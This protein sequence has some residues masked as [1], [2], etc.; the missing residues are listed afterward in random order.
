MAGEVQLGMFGRDDERIGHP[1]WVEKW[2]NR[3]AF[4]IGLMTG[5]GLTAQRICDRLN[6]GVTPNMITA[7]WSHWGHIAGANHHTYAAIPV[8]LSGIHRTLID[9]EAERRRMDIQEI[10]QSVLETVAKEDLW[11]AVLE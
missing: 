1:L 11:K 8:P 3:K 10:C 2:S 5:R 6:D 9:A 7:M 4:E